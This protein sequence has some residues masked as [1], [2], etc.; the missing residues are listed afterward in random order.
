MRGRD[1]SELRPQIQFNSFKALSTLSHIQVSCML[2]IQVCKGRFLYYRRELLKILSVCA[3]N[4]PVK[5]VYM[6]ATTYLPT[7]VMLFAN[8]GMSLL[9][10]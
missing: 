7:A 10:S 6:L 9:G 8:F 1:R 2:T 3:G 5:Y 4:K